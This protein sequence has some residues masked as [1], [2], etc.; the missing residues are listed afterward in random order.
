[1]ADE[2]TPPTS[3]SNSNSNSNSEDP[4]PEG[5]PSRT[6]KKAAS[7][8]QPSGEK[9]SSRP[10]DDSRPRKEKG[11]G[12]GGRKDQKS[13][14]LVFWIIL[15]MVALAFLFAVYRCQKK[16]PPPKPPAKMTISTNDESFY[17]AYLTSLDFLSKAKGAFYQG[18]KWLG[19]TAESQP[20]STS[21]ESLPESP[22]FQSATQFALALEQFK[23]AE[24]LIKNSEAGRAKPELSICR[25]Q[26]L[27]AL[28]KY[29]STARL[30]NDYAKAK[31]QGNND[32]LEKFALSDANARW[33]LAE[34][35]MNDFLVKGC[36]GAIFRYL[37]DQ[38][39]EMR[40]L[41]LGQYRNFL[42]DNYVNYQ[43][44]LESQLGVVAGH[45]TPAPSEIPAPTQ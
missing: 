13:S 38:T 40:S 8:R 41:V 20:E 23:Y 35:L 24:D 43:A 29:Q 44:Q 42:G 4:K 5:A 14:K 32:Q 31:Y 21:A 11:E 30:Y 37:K 12:G 15:A 16:D 33:A 3:N 2:K 36:D 19:G 26:Y 1:M 34:K 10:P 7:D 45:N 27:E 22:V 39:P 18:K 17:K 6:E 25:S 9:P 28:D